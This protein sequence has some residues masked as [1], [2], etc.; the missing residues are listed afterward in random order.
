MNR[1]RV[2]KLSNDNC[3]NSFV[4]SSLDDSDVDYEDS[5]TINFDMKVTKS[6]LVAP[7]SNFTFPIGKQ[8]D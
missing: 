7:I 1:A 3:A 8:E 6:Q 5:S 4:I 2:E